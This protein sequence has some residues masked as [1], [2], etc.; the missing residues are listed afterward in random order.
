M[1]Y[2]HKDI[3]LEVPDSVYCPRE[4]S[5][6]MARCIEEMDMNKRAALEVGCGSGL[7]SIIMSKNGAA[8]TAVDIN[9]DAVDATKKNAD[10]NDSNVN[11]F[12]SDLFEN[13]EG[14]FDLIAFNPPYLPDDDNEPTYSGGKT[15]REVIG[16]FISG[17]KRFLNND[18]VV[19]A[20]ISSLTGEEEVIGMFK[21]IGMK[22]TVIRREKIPWEELLVIKACCD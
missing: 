8:V 2:F 1:K 12:V 18:G 20:I 11:S 17:V 21:S 9:P 6:L 16:R 13:V 3:E 7:L 15:G 14:K 22:T 5:E 19:L 4:D 10:K